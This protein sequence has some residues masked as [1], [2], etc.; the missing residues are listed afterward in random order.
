M[1]KTFLQ[2]L[3]E[4]FVTI[5]IRRKKIKKFVFFIDREIRILKNKIFR[6]NYKKLQT[7]R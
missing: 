5:I 7:L 2:I 1:K 3:T 6:F 4:F